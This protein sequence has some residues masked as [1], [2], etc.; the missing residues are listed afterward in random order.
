MCLCWVKI[1]PFFFDLR[2]LVVRKKSTDDESRCGDELRGCSF[3]WWFV[4]L[5]YILKV[6]HLPYYKYAKLVN[7]FPPKIQVV[8]ATNNPSERDWTL[9]M[10]HFPFHFTSQFT[11]AVLWSIIKLLRNG[12]LLMYFYKLSNTWMCVTW[13][14]WLKTLHWGSTPGNRT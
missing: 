8:T 3:L 4:L 9:I 2:P 13:D 10:P 11:T 5:L 6:S 12:I 1:S 7:P 14:A